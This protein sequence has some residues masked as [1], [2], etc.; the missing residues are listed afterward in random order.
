MKLW[1][2]LSRNVMNTNDLDNFI[3]KLSNIDTIQAWLR[4]VFK[5]WAVNNGPAIRVTSISDDSPDWAKSAFEKGNLY[6]L[7]W[8]SL[9]YLVNPIIDY[10]RHLR[11]QNKKFERMS[12]DEADK[13]QKEWHESLINQSNSNLEEDGI[14]TVM[15]FPDGYQWVSVFG[16]NSL[17]REGEI[18]KHCVGSYYE[19]VKNEGTQIFSLRDPDNDP[20]VTI[21]YQ[22]DANGIAQIKGSSNKQV[23][24]KYRKYCIDFIC[25]KQY[26]YIKDL[27]K[28]DLT[29]S[30]MRSI[31]E[32]AGTFISEHYKDTTFEGYSVKEGHPD[33]PS[34][35]RIQ[36]GRSELYLPDITV[37][38][39]SGTF[40]SNGIIPSK[41]HGILAKL[42]ANYMENSKFGFGLSSYI[43]IG[44]MRQQAA[45]GYIDTAAPE[46]YAAVQSLVFDII[47]K[48]RELSRTI[49]GHKVISFDKRIAS[50][51]ASEV[52]R[53][54]IQNT[55]P[56][57]NTVVYHK[58]IF[59]SALESKTDTL[60]V[61]Y[62]REKHEDAMADV[63]RELLDNRRLEFENS[64]VYSLYSKEKFTRRAVG[65]DYN[66]ASLKF[67]PASMIKDFQKKGYSLDAKKLTHELD[68]CTTK[69]QI[70]AKLNKSKLNSLELFFALS[71]IV[72]KKLLVTALMTRSDLCER[73]HACLQKK[74]GNYITHVIKLLV[75]L[76]ES[77]IHKSKLPNIQKTQIIE[78]LRKSSDD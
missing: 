71:M 5:K 55:C 75:P 73:L 64:W 50:W 42:I 18:M 34:L 60:K 22:S 9:E 14:S 45:F 70:L 52:P 12:V 59:V 65:G 20:H 4:S 17:T 8:E 2:S 76:D 31:L 62:V 27:D 63:V 74:Y 35:D 3:T 1:I 7:D 58:D 68:R 48:G 16:E 33:K 26:D 32:E 24:E 40:H 30:K 21:E 46:M 39:S 57:L 23:S 37:S 49:E 10:L 72:N 44:I 54:G 51:Y 56:S 66:E 11:Q 67:G 38:L 28:L 77:T 78:L 69:A 43:D 53:I 15:T 36:Y 47:R 29:D 61:V 19:E 25:R 6:L 13:Q 41:Y